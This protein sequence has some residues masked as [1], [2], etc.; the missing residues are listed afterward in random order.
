MLLHPSPVYTAKCERN[1]TFK[2]KVNETYGVNTC[3]DGIETTPNEV[4]GVSTDSIKTTPNEVYGVGIDGIKTTP[5]E[6]Y[7]VITDAIEI[8]PNEVYGIDT[9]ES[10]CT[11]I[12]VHGVSTGNTGTGESDLSPVHA[13]EDVH[14]V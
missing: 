11:H 3:T 14:I 10:T 5:N 7:G 8:L 6:V 1:N 2:M 9:N 13:Y 12:K 4:Y